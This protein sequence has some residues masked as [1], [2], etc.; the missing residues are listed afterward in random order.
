MGTRRSLQSSASGGLRVAQI[1][2]TAGY[3]GVEA[4]VLNYYRAIDREKLQFDFFIDRDS[5]FPQ[6]AEVRQMGA[7][8]CR[9]PPCSHA[10]EYL[11]SLR[12][13]LKKGRYP[14]VHANLST[15]NVLPLL[16]AALAGVPVRICHNHSTAHRGE[17]KTF[18]KILLRPLAPL[19]ATHRAACG[20][21][22][23]E[24]MYGRRAVEKGHVLLFPNAVDTAHF[25]YSDESRAAARARLGLTDE[26][27]VG[28]IGR[29]VFQKNH[30]GLLEIFASLSGL[31][32][33][34]RLLLVGEGALQSSLEQKAA[35]LGIADRVLFAGATE[36][37]APFYQAM[38]VFCL[39]SFYEGMPVVAVEA[40]ASGLPCVFSSEVSRE[41]GIL[42]GAVF[43]P[44]DAGCRAWAEALA[45]ALDT[46]P[47]RRDA[48]SKVAA[49]GYDR[50]LAGRKLEAFYLGCLEPPAR[51]KGVKEHG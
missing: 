16:A 27:V 33:R 11:F 7:G 42:P 18:L 39:P 6:E 35:R 2:G 9:L 31:R 26:P 44:L 13:Q 12:R 22:A 5:P 14:I 48:A 19:F 46:A 17:A 36:D 1:L 40:Q 45:A 25:A 49:A 51:N 20:R 8:V 37:P 50:A 29:F 15:L 4:M 24:W 34:A 10:L 28:N 41:A 32:P 30:S 47:V 23:A 3:G 21:Y 43:L 38:D